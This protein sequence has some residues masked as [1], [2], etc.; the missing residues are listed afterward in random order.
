MKITFSSC[1][2]VL[3]SKFDSIKYHEW[4]NNLISITNNFNLVIYTDEKSSVFINTYNKPNI[5]VIIKPIECFITYRF[6]HNWILNHQKNNMLNHNSFTSF[7]TS[8]ELNM[9]WSEKV[10]FVNETILKKYFDTEFYGYCDIGYFR[11]TDEDTHTNNLQNWPSD[12]IIVNLDKTK[13]HYGCICN[14]NIIINY[15]NKII[16]TKNSVG[17]PK[18][19]IPPTQNTISGGFFILHKQMI[20]WW[21]IEYTKKLKLYF[22]QNYLVKDD[23]MIITDCIFSNPTKFKVYQEINLYFDRWFMFQRLLN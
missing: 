17:L 23:Q 6:K 22:E 11:N 14:D 4:M 5:K 1:F 7:N 20:E 2:Y 13:V 12:N 9:L 15:I 19:P 16:I 21:T 18:N 3:K 8:W 10:W